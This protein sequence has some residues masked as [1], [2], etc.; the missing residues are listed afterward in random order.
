[1]H[2]IAFLLQCIMLVEMNW[3]ADN[4][5]FVKRLITSWPVTSARFL[6][7]SHIMITYVSL[8][9]KRQD[10]KAVYCI[11]MCDSLRQVF[12]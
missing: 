5:Y 10:A 3:L 9:D 8:E 1:M 4:V 6:T 7:S 2:I 11:S 12:I